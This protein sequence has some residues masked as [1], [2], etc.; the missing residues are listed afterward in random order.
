[1]S[2]AIPF[3]CLSVCLSTCCCC[4]RVLLS[5]WSKTGGDQ[6]NTT[7]QCTV[8]IHHEP[9]KA[10]TQDRERQ[11]NEKGKTTQMR[12]TTQSRR[13]AQR[14]HQR[15]GNKR[16]SCGDTHTR[17]VPTRVSLSLFFSSFWIAHC[18]T[19]KSR[20]GLFHIVIIPPHTRWWSWNSPSCRLD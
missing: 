11:S 9:D 19:K 2:L 6:R 7:T 1:M 13:Q 12:S 3:V 10:H 14:T 8:T 17:F 4:P 5:A 18:T 20:C 16:A 15:Q